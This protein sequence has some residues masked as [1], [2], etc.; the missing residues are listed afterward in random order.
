MVFEAHIA[1]PRKLEEPGKSANLPVQHCHLDRLTQH[2]ETQ[3]HWLPS[4]RFCCYVSECKWQG[5]KHQGLLTLLCLQAYDMLAQLSAH[6]VYTT[7]Q[8]KLIRAVM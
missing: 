2:Q 7:M 5:Q 1:E 3:V 8:M 6:A 4:L